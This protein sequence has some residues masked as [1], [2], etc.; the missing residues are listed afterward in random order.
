MNSLL[1]TV[2]NQLSE[3]ART[4]KLIRDTMSQNI[5]TA[6]NVII[7]CLRS[8]GKVLVCGNGGSAADSQH[9]A[10]EMIGRFLREREPI[11]FIALTTNTS[12]ITAIGN[13]YTFDKIFLR[14]IEALG[15]SGDILFGISTS[16]NSGNVIEAFK[17]AKEKNMITIALLGSG[18][19]MAEMA[20]HVLSVPVKATPRIQ[21][22][23]I[24]IIHILCD[25]IESAMFKNPQ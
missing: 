19:K 10:A 22:G 4:K 23:H 1:K 9:F 17:K 3:S 11:S 2:Q 6:A 20:D 24:T 13:D 7:T 21:E 5:V 14:Q 15:Q 12:T 8:G 18:G 25:L 16:G